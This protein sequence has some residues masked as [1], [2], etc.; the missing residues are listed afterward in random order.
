MAKADT[1]LQN[2]VQH[3]CYKCNRKGHYGTQCIAKT[4]VPKQPAA[5]E[6]VQAN[7]NPAFLGTVSATQGCAWS[8]KVKVQDTEVTFKLDTGAEVTVIS[9]KTFATLKNVEVGEAVTSAVRTTQTL[10]ESPRTIRGTT[11]I[12]A[13]NDH[14]KHQVYATTCLVYPQS[15][16]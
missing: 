5:A 2:S 6:E 1:P 7:E 12:R 14:R 13:T 10:P 8:Q 4:K 11:V 16:R 15:S 3:E 9:D